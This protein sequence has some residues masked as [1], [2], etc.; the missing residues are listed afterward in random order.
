LTHGL[1]KE[2]EAEHIVEEI[3][4]SIGHVLSCVDADHPGELPTDDVEETYIPQTLPELDKP[5]VVPD[6]STLE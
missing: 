1:L 2:Q 6:N 5:L 3:E 4:E